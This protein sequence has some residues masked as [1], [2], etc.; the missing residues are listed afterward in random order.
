MLFAVRDRRHKLIERLVPH[1]ETGLFDYLADPLETRNLLEASPAVAARLRAI[2]LP[3][4]RSVLHGYH[5]AVGPTPRPHQIRLRAETQG[6][7]ENTLRLVVRTGDRLEVTPDRRTVRLFAEVGEQGRYLV[8][9]TRP[10]D[11]AIR[12]SLEGDRG[13]EEPLPLLGA[14]DRG[15]AVGDAWLAASELSV[16]ASRVGDLLEGLAGRWRIY[17]V[18]SEVPGSVVEMDLRL[19]QELEAL[20]YLGPP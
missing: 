15:R 2:L 17:Y 14:A 19:R 5:V 10:T 12:V 7:F 9:Q 20:G 16:P 1:S 13:T 3:T 8:L 11:A 18:P 6:V 4:I